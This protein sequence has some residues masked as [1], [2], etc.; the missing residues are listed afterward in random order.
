[1]NHKKENPMSKLTSL[2]RRAPKRFSAVAL[3]VAA[4]IIIPTVTLAWG[5]DRPTFTVANP[6]DH[7]TFDSITDNPNYGDERNF[8]TIKDNTNTGAG[9]WK[10][11]ISVANNGEYTVRMYVHNNANAN[12]NLVAQNVTA[13]FNL[14]TYSA[15]RIQIDGYLN[16]TNASPTQIYDQA[17]FS[18]ASNFSLKYI[19]GSAVYTNNVFTSGT[20]LPDSVISSGAKLGYDKLDGNIPGCFQY[21]GYVTFKVKAVTDSFSVQK[22][23]RVNGATDK[24]FKETVAVKAGDKVDYQIYFKNNGG[25]QLQNV[26]IK[27]TLPKGVT[28]VAGSTYTNTSEG[29]KLAADGVTAGGLNIGVFAPGGDAYIKFT[30]TVNPADTDLVCGGNTLRNVAKATT[31]VGSQEDTADVTIDKTCVPV[32]GKITVCELSTKKIVTIKES[33]FNTSKYSKNL[34]DCKSTPVTPPTTTTPPELPHTGASENILAFT[35]LGALIASIT[36]YV[37]SRRALNQ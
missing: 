27:D 21:T 1:M 16:S 29:V 24:T 8:V 7:V 5:P 13:N 19:T 18:S 6:A 9:N 35:G 31:S 11:E 26:V 34:D 28:Y 15:K 10:D 3:M 30:A 23:V 12:L 37:A 33:D 36:Y 4:A 17:V 22:T 32:P 20:A 25:T 14:P 2:I